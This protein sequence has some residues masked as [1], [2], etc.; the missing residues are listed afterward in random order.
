MG[1]ITDK[2]YL[3]LTDA[4]WYEKIAVVILIA[5]VVFIGIMPFKLNELITPATETIIQHI[6]N[7]LAL[8]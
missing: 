3:Q 2:H 8:K 4:V 5:G 6:T 7:A 1:P